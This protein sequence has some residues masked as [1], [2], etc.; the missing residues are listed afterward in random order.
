[1]MDC[2]KTWRLASCFISEA[3]PILCFMEN[4]S[5]YIGSKY[6]YPIGIMLGI[7]KWYVLFGMRGK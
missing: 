3:S 2:C 1:M 7:E 5:W 4:G 6:G